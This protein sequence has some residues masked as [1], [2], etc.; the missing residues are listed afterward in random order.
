VKPELIG[1]K[2]PWRVT[3]TDKGIPDLQLDM[4]KESIE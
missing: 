2:S 4:D 1:P 3:V